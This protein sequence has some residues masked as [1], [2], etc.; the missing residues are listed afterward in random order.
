MKVAYRTNNTIQENL[1]PKT[2]IHKKF[3][4]TGIYKLTCL[5]CGKT[6][7]GQTGWNFS[8]RYNEHLR[9]F[10]NN[11]DSSNFAQYLNEDMHTFWPLNIF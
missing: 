5:D 4:A 2:H 8:K 9:A 10:R 1:T 11:C 7:I 3:L 6:Y